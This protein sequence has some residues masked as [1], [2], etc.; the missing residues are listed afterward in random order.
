MRIQTN[1]KSLVIE[2]HHDLIEIYESPNLECVKCS[3]EIVYFKNSG[4]N[5]QWSGKADIVHLDKSDVNIDSGVNC[6][7]AKRCAKLQVSNIKNVSLTQCN[8]Q[9]SNVEQMTAHNCREITC[10]NIDV[11]KFSGSM[12]H[13]QADNVHTI[14]IQKMSIH[15]IDI[16]GKCA[17]EASELIAFSI[18]AP[19]T[20][21][22]QLHWSQIESFVQ[23]RYFTEF[24]D[25]TPAIN[26]SWRQKFFT[27]P[28]RGGVCP[29]LHKFALTH[30][31]FA[32]T[33]P[34]IYNS[35]PVQGRFLHLGKYADKL[36]KQ[37]KQK[38]IARKLH[39]LDPYFYKD[40]L[41]VIKQYL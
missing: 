4:N 30:P 26:G 17:F 16:I 24:F 14:A 40:V 27:E 21:I 10:Q 35:R 23:C 38:I 11:A 31:S 7:Y 2:G 37:L 13:I 25:A 12:L 6:L 5:C 8:A 18:N 33:I 29:L 9:I 3:A 41:S 36:K 39:E 20:T 34:G 22:T 32:N 28:I 1:N 19:D 15:S